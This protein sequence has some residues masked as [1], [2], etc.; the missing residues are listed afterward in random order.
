MTDFHAQPK[1]GYLASLA[2]FPP[3]IYPFQFNPDQLTDTKRANWGSDRGGTSRGTSSAGGGN[4]NGGA[5]DEAQRSRLGTYLARISGA[6]LMK[7]S[8]G[9]DRTI[10]FNIRIDGRA[11]RPGEPPRRRADDGNILIDLAILRSFVYP[12]VDLLAVLSKVLADKPVVWDEAL[13]AQP[14]PA[15]L[16]LGDLTLECVVTEVRITETLFNKNL[17][18]VVA[19][20]GIS[21]TE[22]VDSLGFISETA[23]RMARLTVGTAY[24]DLPFLVAK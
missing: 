12:N 13:F 21:L 20:V 8:E 2:M 19:E 14:P 5:A 1:R 18:P 7:F 10:S 24:E 15:L 23:K 3:L 6:G 11:Q 17:D 16:V 4:P 22:K 9:G